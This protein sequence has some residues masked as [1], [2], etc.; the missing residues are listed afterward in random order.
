MYS[1][2][3]IDDEILAIQHLKRLLEEC[4]PSLQVVAQYTDASAALMDPLIETADVLFVDIMMPVMNG[5]EFSERLLQ[6]NPYAKVILLTAYRDFEYAKRAMEIGVHN[7]WVKHELRG[8][9]FAVQL[10]SVLAA[11]EEAR[12]HKMG[13]QRQLLI[14]ALNEK[15]SFDGVFSSCERRA[16]CFLLYLRAPER[17]SPEQFVLP[18]EIRG[19][20]SFTIHCFEVA[21]G[22]APAWARAEALLAALNTKLPASV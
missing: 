19:V 10:E 20:G 5:L 12:R 9:H 14:D 13:R 8:S 11:V 2:A 15:V 21:A 4:A 6:K 3:I 7:Y 1:V 22:C 17:V 18:T 16:L